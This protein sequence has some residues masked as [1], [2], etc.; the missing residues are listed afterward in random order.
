MHLIQLA[1]QRT[2][3]RSNVLYSAVRQVD[4]WAS[5]AHWFKSLIVQKYTRLAL[6]NAKRA[7]TDVQYRVSL[8]D[9]VQTYLMFLSK[10]I[11]RCDCRQG[12]LTT[13]IQTWF[14]SSKAE[15]VRSAESN[16]HTSYEELMGSALLHSSSDPDSS[17]ESLQELSYKAKLVDPGGVVRYSLGIP[18]FFSSSQLKKLRLF[19]H[20]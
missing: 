19:T 15:I 2:G 8:D 6:M 17:F 18:E 16:Q 10:A 11:D 9:V 7:Y 12:V 1:E 4:F 20:P 3:V 14:H 5:K 13:F